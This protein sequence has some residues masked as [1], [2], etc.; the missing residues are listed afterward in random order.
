MGGT[1]AMRLS[2]HNPTTFAGAA[3]W[4]GAVWWRDEDVLVAARE[5]SAVLRQAGFRALLINGDED[6]HGD[7]TELLPI[8]DAAGIPYTALQLDH[9]THNLGKYT[10]RT[11]GEFGELLRAI[12]NDL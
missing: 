11:Q 2:I 8:L 10:Q 3:S 9:Q 12:W 6:D 7:Y 4:G 5:N 1:A